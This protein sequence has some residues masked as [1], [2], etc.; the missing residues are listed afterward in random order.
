MLRSHLL[1]LAEFIK[2]AWRSLHFTRARRPLI[3]IVT[4][5]TAHECTPGVDDSSHDHS[6]QSDRLLSKLKVGVLLMA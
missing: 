6:F 4:G 5:V 2:I 1:P 3:T